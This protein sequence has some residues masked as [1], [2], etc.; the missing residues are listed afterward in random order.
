MKILGYYTGSACVNGVPSYWEISNV[1]QYVVETESGNIQIITPPLNPASILLAEVT[2][3]E[4]SEECPNLFP[5]IPTNLTWDSITALDSRLMIGQ[6]TFDE[7]FSQRELN[8]LRKYLFLLVNAGHFV[9]CKLRNEWGIEKSFPRIII[10]ATGPFNQ[11][12]ARGHFMPG[13]PSDFSRFFASPCA[14][15]AHEL[16]HHLTGFTADDKQLIYFE[17]LPYSLLPDQLSP[18][19]PN[20]DLNHYVLT[21]LIADK[22]ALQ[23]CGFNESQ[24]DIAAKI[25]GSKNN[26]DPWVLL[27][28]LSLAKEF[29]LEADEKW[30]LRKLSHNHQPWE[31]TIS[32]QDLVNLLSEFFQK[33]TLKGQHT[34]IGSSD[35]YPVL[36][37]NE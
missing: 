23:L 3:P 10:Q 31:N 5:Q 24:K 27:F 14:L 36:W 30:L 1:S 15:Y 21:E 35:L 9:E 16:G 28:L 20:G 37:P 19:S 17:T 2:E 29:H 11:A 32:T 26:R 18:S 8:S 25:K 7:N 4:M 13:D 6:E 12:Y 34:I 22:A 33:V